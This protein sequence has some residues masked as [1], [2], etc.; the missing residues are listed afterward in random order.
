MW[1]WALAK[2]GLGVPWCPAYGVL[3]P[4]VNLLSSSSK[5]DIPLLKLYLGIPIQSELDLTKQPC[6]K[7]TVEALSYTT[8]P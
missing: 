3:L 7:C 1:V 4:C 6:E 5:A 8:T 2:A